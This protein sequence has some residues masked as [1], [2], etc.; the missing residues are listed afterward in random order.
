M[1]SKSTSF[2]A[3]A[4]RAFG[5]LFLVVALLASSAM[6][7]AAERV[8]Y[9]YDQVI[10]FITNLH[11]MKIVTSNTVAPLMAQIVDGLIDHHS[12]SVILKD[13]LLHVRA[14]RLS[15]EM[16]A[17]DQVEEDLV[18]ILY[19]TRLILPYYVTDAS[20][21]RYARKNG[22][23]M[24]RHIARIYGSRAVTSRLTVLE[25]YPPADV[26]A[27]VEVISNPDYGYAGYG[28][29]W[30]SESFFKLHYDIRIVELAK[31]AI[32]V[33]LRGEEGMITLPETGYAVF[34]WSGA[35]SIPVDLRFT[36]WSFAD[37]DAL[38][39]LLDNPYYAEMARNQLRRMCPVD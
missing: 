23:Y 4:K 26:A 32:I 20:L 17:A 16:K 12:F 3:L 15:K 25:Q 2:P 37:M 21:G 28:A 24:K 36:R 14:S 8:P 34:R 11:I 22:L 18:R 35:P 39:A 6:A 30:A 19:H 31:R 9:T 1:K 10:G 5:G 29:T 27:L 7:I 33:S 38:V 13:Q